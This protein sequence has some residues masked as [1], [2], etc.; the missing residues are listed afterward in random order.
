MEEAI[1]ECEAS[2]K[3]KCSRRQDHGEELQLCTMMQGQ[4]F[5]KGPREAV[6]ESPA[7]FS[8][9]TQHFSDAS[10]M[11]LPLRAA[12]VEYSHPE[13]TGYGVCPTYITQKIEN[14]PKPFV[15]QIMCD[16][17]RWIV[18][19]LYCGRLGLLCS[20]CESI[21]MFSLVSEKIFNFDCTSSYFKLERP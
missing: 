4:S 6:G 18:S 20:D 19:Y 3:V 14:L 13:T 16:L 8:S 2:V 11:I 15:T 5:W 21:L 12:T 9:Q 1:Q 10:A 7:S 17:T